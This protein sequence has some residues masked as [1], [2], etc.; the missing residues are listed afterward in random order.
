MTDEE[1]LVKVKAGL[2]I[3]SAYNDTQLQIKVTA[4]K[5]YMLNAGITQEQLETDLGIVTLT[6][7]VN[8]LWNLASGEV[9]FSDAFTLY[10]MP[11]LMVVSLPDV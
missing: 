3:S 1:I 5:E 7:G 6:V 10:L 2:S 9:K 11:Q 4:V 8:D